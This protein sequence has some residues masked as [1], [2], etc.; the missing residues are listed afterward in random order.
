[1]FTHKTNL[2]RTESFLRWV[3]A[4]HLFGTAALLILLA[5]TVALRAQEKNPYAGD[6]K[7]GNGGISVSFELRVLPWAGRKRR[8]ARSRPDAG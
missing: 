3:G 8:R 7:V 4:R 6:A 1:M 5:P 2:Q